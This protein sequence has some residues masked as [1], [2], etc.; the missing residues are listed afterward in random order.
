LPCH[1]VSFVVVKSRLL[2]F[3]LSLSIIPSDF[4][5]RLVQ[6]SKQNTVNAL[7]SRPQPRPSI[8]TRFPLKTI[9]IASWITSPCG[10]VA[11]NAHSL[12]YLFLY[13]QL[14]RSILVLSQHHRHINT[15][16]PP[17]IGSSNHRGISVSPF[18]SLLRAIFSSHFSFFRPISPEAASTAID[19]FLLCVSH[20]RR[21]PDIPR[22]SRDQAY[23]RAVAQL[24]TIY[25]PPHPC[26]I[27][28][29]VP[30]AALVLLSYILPHR[31]HG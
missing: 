20:S 8:H 19:P 10:I 21:Y 27:T 22:S 30:S 14:S 6:R 2:I 24:T 26:S 12:L 4:P 7:T 23:P 18:L 1:H 15:H 13:S 11:G 28:R 29:L 25:P 31:T 3:F 16:R 9:P 5:F 17:R